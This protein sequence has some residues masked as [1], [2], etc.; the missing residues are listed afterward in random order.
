MRKA[1]RIGILLLALVLGC[2]AA[3]SAWAEGARVIV[4]IGDSYSS[5]EGIEPFYGQ[6]KEM[7]ERCADPDW[8][9]HRSRQNW[10][11]L[12][13]LP[14]VDGPM[15]DHRGENWFFAAASGAQTKHLFLLT[16][17][18]IRD[19]A[20][21][22]QEKQY[23]R[24]G[25]SGTA[26]LA[27]QLDIFDELDR[28]G[29]KADYVTVTI[30]GNDIGFAGVVTM[31]YSGMSTLL[32]GSTVEEKA[33]SLW[34]DKYIED[35][36]RENIRRAYSDIARRAGPQACI[37]V[38]GYPHVLAPYCGEYEFPGDSPAIMNAAVDM[39]NAELRDIVEECRAEG[40]NIVFVSVTEA[41]EGH[42]AYSD[43]PYINP[44]KLHA[45]PQDLKEKMTASMYSMHPNAEGA[46]AYARCVQE[47]IDRLEAEK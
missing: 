47:A 44:V 15:K 36:V 40:M 6:E 28:L 32:P 30:G 42:G 12:L 13:T 18:E 38:A 35:G 17:E 34:R 3:L 27:P 4:S 8:L 2:G 25:V 23:D 14:A 33:E 46:A 45:A 31:S 39:F 37:I 11:G 9:A 29:L 21:A 24:D 41:F 20:S 22:E 1:T 7:T 10:P 19:G 5:G 43:E 26:L 16:E